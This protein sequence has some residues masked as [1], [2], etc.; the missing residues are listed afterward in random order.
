MLGTARAEQEH[1]QQE[2][3]WPQASSAL[4]GSMTSESGS[5]EKRPDPVQ[6]AVWRPGHDSSGSNTTAAAP[7]GVTSTHR[8]SGERRCIARSQR[9]ATETDKRESRECRWTQHWAPA[10][11]SCAGS[12]ESVTRQTPNSQRGKT[13]G[14]GRTPQYQELR[15]QEHE[16]EGRRPRASSALSGTVSQRERE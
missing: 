5:K 4:C 6:L 13:P 15:D 14:A 9:R 3:R 7:T 2:G 10:T 8:S 12:S 1:E 16:Q 11:G